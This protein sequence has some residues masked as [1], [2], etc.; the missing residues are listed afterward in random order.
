MKI[1]R[2]I[3]FAAGLATLVACSDFEEIN[4]N[5]KAANASDLMPYWSLNKAIMSDQQNPNDAERVFVLYW[6]DIARQDGEN[7]GRSVGASNDEWAGCL[8]NL[9]RNC[10][11]ASNLAIKIA[12]EAIAGGALGEHETGLFANVKEFARIWRVYLM[13]EFVDSFGSFT[14]DFEANTPEYKSVQECYDF[15]LN[16]CK[17]AV[18]NINLDFSGESATEQDADAAYLLDAAK[19]KN[20]GISMWMRIAMRL[21][22]VDAAKAKSNFEAA[23]AAGPG[24]RTIDGIFRI[25]ERNAW[26]DLAGV[27]SRTWDWQEASHTFA[28]LTT[29]LGGADVRDVLKDPGKRLY[30][31]A[32]LSE[33]KVNE[34]YGAYIKD[35][36]TYL[37]I[38][39]VDQSG[40]NLY[41]ENTDSPTWGYFFDG[42]PSKL[43]PRAL[44]YFTLPCDYSNRIE[45]GYASFPAST[46]PLTTPID[47]PNQAFTVD[48]SYAWNGLIA[49]YGRDDKFS[50]SNGLLD[51]SSAGGVHYGKTYPALA[52]RY[53]N[54]QEFRVFFGPWETYFLLAEAAVRGWNTGISAEQAY[55]AGIKASFE[56]LD[57]DENYDAY[58]NSED[59]NRV[60][61]SVKFSHTAEPSNYTINYTDPVSGTVK[62]TEYKYPDANKVMYKGKKL[63]DQLT[64]IITQKFIAN[65][66]WLP[67]ENWSDHRRLGL[68]FWELPVSTTDFP[69]LMEGAKNAYKTGQKPGCYAQR[70]N[71]PNSFK[72]ASP[73]QYQNAISLMGMTNE[74]TITPLWWAIQ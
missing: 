47:V 32:P 43:D 61:T 30:K 17:E 39:M 41:E 54:S 70:M 16:E 7:S 65:T 21:S 22:E 69:Y 5:P 8:Y 19:W 74:N 31:N 14:T 29:N 63:N 62:T 15:M 35:A 12:D 49:G 4:K 51:N 45:T 58:I 6:A 53:R 20:F 50:N 13:T 25:E 26:N 37:G 48:V 33:E 1:N 71:Y 60:G 28:N 9:T 38:H 23:V 36:A 52:E 11:N 40:A 72:N 66:P 56:Y 59:Y 64:K 10:V 18:A 3:A 46:A 73:E 34:I 27:M 2:I 55:N 57:I 44:V 42:I 24:I 68:P 67:L